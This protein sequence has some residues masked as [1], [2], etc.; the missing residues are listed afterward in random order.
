MRLF[1]LRLSTTLRVGLP[2]SF[3]SLAMTI[4]I[5]RTCYICPSLTV[6]ECRRGVK[7]SGRVTPTRFGQSLQSNTRE[8]VE[9]AGEQ[10]QEALQVL[11]TGPIRHRPGAGRS[12]RF[13][14][15]ASTLPRD[16]DVGIEGA[17]TAACPG[18]GSPCA[19]RGGQPSRWASWAWWRRDRC[20]SP[21][22]RPAA[23]RQTRSGLAH[24]ASP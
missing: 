16:H 15:V 11:G 14:S 20:C 5:K 2:R 4:Q 6:A 7:N 23:Y 3:R 8:Y 24:P 22:Y 10:E 1:R 21:G 9:P 18:S 17:G 12:A 19:G 13:V